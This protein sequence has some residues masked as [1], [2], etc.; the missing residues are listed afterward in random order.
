MHCPKLIVQRILFFV[1]KTYCR[2]KGVQLGQNCIIGGLP[3]ILRKNGGKIILGDDVTIHSHYIFNPLIVHRSTLC[4]ETR[5]ACIHFGEHSGGSGISIIC[6]AG[7]S[8]GK[9]TIIGAGTVIDDKKHHQFTKEHGWTKVCSDTAKSIRIGNYCYIGMRSLIL[10]GVTI[11]D[12]CVV[13]AGSVISEDVP[14]GYLA[15]GN[16]ATLHPLPERLRTRPDGTIVPLGE[17]GGN[18]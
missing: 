5:D 6:S 9:H 12:Y 13:S 11:G 18:K 1:C 8:V 15:E 4:A 17:M 7:V 10:K 14:T 3:I 16:P 2:L